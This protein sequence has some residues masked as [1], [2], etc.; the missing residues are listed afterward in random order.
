MMLTKNDWQCK[1]LY[2]GALGTVLYKV[3][4][5]EKVSI[6][7]VSLIVF[8]WNSMITVVH[9]LQM[10]ID[11]SQLFLRMFSLMFKVENLEVVNSF[12]SF[13]DG[14]LPYISPRG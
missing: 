11:V 5:S 7:Q 10:A 3:S 8:W 9:R 13:W 2:N 14:Q 1:G 6:L 4:C 12:H